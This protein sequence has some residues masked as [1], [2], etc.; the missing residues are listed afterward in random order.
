MLDVMIQRLTSQA[1]SFAGIVGANVHDEDLVA[2]AFQASAEASCIPAE[3]R[4]LQLSGGLTPFES[5]TTNFSF[6]APICNLLIAVFELD[7]QNNWLRRQA[8]VLILQ[9]V[10]GGAIE[11]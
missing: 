4:L 9:Q 3:D 8:T 1:A 5:E 11:R 2:R 10:L 6:S 7:L